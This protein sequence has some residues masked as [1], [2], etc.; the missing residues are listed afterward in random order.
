MIVGY[1]ILAY[2]HNFVYDIAWFICVQMNWKPNKVISS[3][4]IAG[5]ETDLKCFFGL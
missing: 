2:L 1:I 3:A 4:L 5:K